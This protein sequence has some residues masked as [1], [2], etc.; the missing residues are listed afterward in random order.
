[1]DNKKPKGKKHA[2]RKEKAQKKAESGGRM[3]I[4]ELRSPL[5]RRAGETTDLQVI[6]IAVLKQW[7]LP[8]FQR[9]L[10]MN[11]QFHEVVALITKEQGIVPGT[12]T[13]GVLDGR[14]YV[15]DGQHRLRALELAMDG[16][17]KEGLAEC[18]IKHFDSMAEMAQ[19]Y[20][21]LNRPIAKMGPDDILRGMESSIESLLLIRRRC[22][23]VGYDNIR[24]GPK[25]AAMVSM[26]GILRVWN[27]ATK[28]T[29]ASG[30]G[31]SAL[32][33]AFGLSTDDANTCCDFLSICERAWGRDEA[34]RKLWG[35]LNLSLCGW[36]YRRTVFAAY[37]GRSARLTKEQFRSCLQALSVDEPYLEYLVG[38]TLSERDRS[39]AYDKIKSIFVRRI[40]SEIGK[41]VAL[42]APPWAPGHQRGPR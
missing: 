15:V 14:M 4:P 29:P 33:L 32:D 5:E 10:R 31:G 1:M 39:P 34:Y 35:A 27:A 8:P 22:D 11:K 21:N 7:E 13:I 24:R 26:S 17:L 25:A 38:R 23:F 2:G 16:G 19:E 9:P 41:R 40:N 18:R 42:P 28:E 37:S 36:L 30:S 3:E 12:L 20:V 6:T